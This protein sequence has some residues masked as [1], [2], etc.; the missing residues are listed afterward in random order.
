MDRGETVNAT[1][2]ASILKEELRRAIKNK[3]SGLLSDGVILL[4]DNARPHTARHTMEI[5][6]QLGWEIL[7]HPPYSPDLSPCDFH[8]FGLMK[9]ALAGRHFQSDDEGKEAVQVWCKQ[10]TK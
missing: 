3:R 5:V 9:A 2:Y 4:Q 7:E 10:Q 6:A 1:R 8:T